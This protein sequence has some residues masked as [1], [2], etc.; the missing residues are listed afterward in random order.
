MI[1][2]NRCW[3][4]LA[5]H[6]G[7]DSGETVASIRGKVAAQAVGKRHA[8]TTIPLTLDEELTLTKLMNSCDV[9]YVQFVLRHEA[10]HN[11][12]FPP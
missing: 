1:L 8:F 3:R 6:L 11:P 4:V 10:E 2:S 12:H 5:K 9:P 7:D